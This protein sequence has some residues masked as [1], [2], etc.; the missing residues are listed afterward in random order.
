MRRRPLAFVI[1][2]L[3]AVAGGAL[4]APGSLEREAIE[5]L[6]FAR[7]QLRD[8]ADELRAYRDRFT[9]IVAHEVPGDIGVQTFEGPRA[10][11]DAIGFVARLR[12][13]APVAYDPALARAAADHAEDQSRTGA[14]GHVGSDGSRLGERIGRY[15]KGRGLVAEIISYGQPTA[16]RVI[17]QLVVDDGE[18]S[19]AHRADVFE[20]AFKRA[21]AACRRHPVY[22]Y[23]CVIDLSGAPL[24]ER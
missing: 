10:V 15:S 4:A 19:R 2:A 23:V 1:L 16:E 22:Q 8:Y 5:E 12:P 20:P 13:T 14:I 11:E 18:R 17:R 3:F 24:G 7:D 9:G 21:G 6:N